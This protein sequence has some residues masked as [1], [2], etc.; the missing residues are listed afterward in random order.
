MCRTLS[1]STTQEI[2]PR[3]ILIQPIYIADINV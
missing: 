1:Q 2:P 3:R